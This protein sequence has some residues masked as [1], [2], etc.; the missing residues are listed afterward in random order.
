MLLFNMKHLLVN[1]FVKIFESK[2]GFFLSRMQW[3][4][5]SQVEIAVEHILNRNF[6]GITQIPDKK[7]PLTSCSL[8]SSFKI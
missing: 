6:V 2:K 3:I 4:L 8:I 5:P 1:F 7:Q